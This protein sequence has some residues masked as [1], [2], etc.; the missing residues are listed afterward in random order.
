MRAAAGRIRS[1]VGARLHLQQV[2]SE[3]AARAVE[4]R[5]LVERLAS[6]VGALRDELTAVQG[7]QSDATAQVRSLAPRL[8]RMEAT[9][10]E[11]QGA[12]ADGREA[13][14]RHERLSRVHY[15]DLGRLRT[16]LT[17]LRISDAYAATF[18][19]ARPLVSVPIATYNA[20]ELLVER[21][22]ASVRAQTYEEWEVVVVGDACT[23]NTAARVE[24][25][26]DPRIRFVNLPFRTLDVD[27]PHERWLVSGSGPQN[28]AVALSRGEWL[29]P[30]D[31]DDEFLPDHIEILL[32]LA[33]AGRSELAYGKIVRPDGHEH[34]AAPPAAGQIGMQAV[35][36]LSSLGT[37]FEWDTRSW[38]VDE[39]ADW[40]LIRRMR[41]AGVLMAATD[42]PV[43]RYYPS[44]SMRV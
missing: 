6:E 21:A 39:P 19:K 5:P 43:T 17:A 16:A 26:R 27:D 11:A 4:L 12:L 42:T 15:D 38:A 33:L 32:D 37:I 18:A 25:L 40:N 22:L 7:S 23:D 1:A 31:D 10:A 44:F 29:A 35:L 13:Q 2:R 9:L 28:V 36:Y 30:L 41:E 8:E 3:A 20:A 14:M 34:F 24:A